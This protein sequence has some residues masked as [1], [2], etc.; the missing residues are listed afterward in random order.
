MAHGSIDHAR[1]NNRLRKFKALKLSHFM[2]IRFGI[3]IHL[4]LLFLTLS[5]IAFG[6]TTSKITQ[7][8]E[9][10]CIDKKLM[11]TLIHDLKEREILIKKDSISRIYISILNNELT[12]GHTKS[13]E[14]EKSLNTEQGK[15]RRNGWQRNSFIVLSILLSYLCIK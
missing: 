8:G 2:I 10:I 3:L 12:A 7:K 1:R 4:I 15:R 14:L 13:Y 5:Q 6:Q 11:D 9:Q